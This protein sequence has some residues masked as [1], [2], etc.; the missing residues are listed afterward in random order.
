MIKPKLNNDDKIRHGR[1]HKGHHRYMMWQE[2][3]PNDRAYFDDRVMSTH[4]DNN[5]YSFNGSGY[6]QGSSIVRVPSI[7]RSRKIWKNFYKMFPKYKQI[8]TECL[9]GERKCSISN[10]TVAVEIPN[11]THRTVSFESTLFG[12]PCIK[13]RSNYPGEVHDN[14]VKLR[15]I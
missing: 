7:K 2:S 1:R 12:E 13:M 10:D 9:N 15:I 8:L 6:P 11:T 4:R 14:M 5:G 3:Y